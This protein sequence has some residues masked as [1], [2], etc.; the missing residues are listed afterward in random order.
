MGLTKPEIGDKEVEGK[1]DLR[2]CGA[3][4]HPGEIEIENRNSVIL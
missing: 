4:Q 3:R 2:N 1:K